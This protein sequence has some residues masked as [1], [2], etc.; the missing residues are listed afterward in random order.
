ME[1]SSSSVARLSLPWWRKEQREAA[2]A[3]ARWRRQA[4]LSGAVEGRLDPRC[5]RARREQMNCRREAKEEAGS[6]RPRNRRKGHLP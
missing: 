5:L 3:I 2:A 1:L 6:S 4:D